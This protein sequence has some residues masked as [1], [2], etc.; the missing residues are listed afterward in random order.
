[1]KNFIEIIFYLE[2]KNICQYCLRSFK[3]KC[4]TCSQNYNSIKSYKGNCINCL[5]PICD[6]CNENEYKCNYCDNNLCYSCY[7]N[8]REVEHINNKLWCGCHK[9]VEATKIIQ[10]A[11][12]KYRYIPKYK[13]CEKVLENN[14][15]E[16]GAL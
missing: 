15:K 13:F 2:K 4:I 14:L 6:S 8:S 9:V 5:K 7:N 11:F 12:R 3:W 1:M 10:K 16:I